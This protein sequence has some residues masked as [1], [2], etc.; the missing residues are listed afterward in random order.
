[1]PH[2]EILLSVKDASFAYDV[3]E[4]FH[5]IS[6]DLYASEVLCLMGGNGCGKSTL[7]DSILG[8]HTLREGNIFIKNQ[9]V[10]NMKIQERAREVAYVPQV[11]DKSFPYKVRQVILM[12]R[13]AHMGGF[14]AP[15]QEDKEI[16]K[17][18]MDEIGI[19]HLADRPYTQ[20]SGGEMQMII[21][22]RALV[23]DTSVILMD[24]PTAHLDFYNELLFLERVAKFSMS[25]GKG[26]LMA[27][28]SPNQAFFLQSKGINVR[29]IL[30]KDGGI[31][32]SG[33]P[34][35]VLT[36]QNLGYVYQVA[37]KI[38]D[39]SGYKQIVPLHTIE[40][41]QDEKI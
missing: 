8:V 29:V 14:S 2:K 31:V 22:A 35:D 23:Q 15:G 18:V 20:I 21:L 40:R 25:G 30:M 1:M 4:I 27:P 11:H 41:K 9:N 26:I 32:A 3:R 6:F 5:R 39:T 16:V 28:H 13:T 38:N 24:E 12:G 10:K 19:S 37:T 17:K 34:Q 33:T 36:E 7:L